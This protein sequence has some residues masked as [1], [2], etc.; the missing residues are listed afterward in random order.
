MALEDWLSPGFHPLK[1][2]AVKQAAE[3]ARRETAPKPEPANR[4]EPA[5]KPELVHREP[6]PVTAGTRHLEQRGVIRL[7]D[8]AAGLPATLEELVTFFRDDIESWGRGEALQAGIRKACE[9]YCFTYQNRQPVGGEEDLRVRCCDCKQDKCPYP[10][11]THQGKQLYHASTQLRWCDSFTPG[12]SVQQP[13][14]RAGWFSRNRAASLDEDTLADLGISTEI[15][16]FADETLDDI[17]EERH[18]E[19]MAEYVRIAS[20]PRQPGDNLSPLAQANNFLLD[21]AGLKQ[22]RRL[23][24][25]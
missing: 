22:W 7:R 10:L 2:K 25:G 17:P 6:E 15:Q 9:W 21:Q 3:P 16:M 20:L 4:Q 18:E 8:A 13:K 14:G 5:H 12:G 11:A 23:D 1:P 24:K 19:V